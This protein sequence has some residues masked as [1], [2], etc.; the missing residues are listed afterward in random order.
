MIVSYEVGPTS[1]HFRPPEPGYYAPSFWVSIEN[2]VISWGF[3]TVL[4]L[5]W[6]CLRSPFVRLE[7]AGRIPAAL[8]GNFWNSQP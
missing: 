2:S 8:E 6:E 4:T 7:E 5:G 1:D 3:S